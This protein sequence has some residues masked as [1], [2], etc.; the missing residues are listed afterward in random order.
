M[1]LM[2]LHI[3]RLLLMALI[4]LPA[5]TSCYN[6]DEE[7]SVVYG[8][9][10]KYIN[11]TLSVSASNEAVTRA[12]PVG[13]E[14]G[15]G[16][17]KGNNRENLVNTISIFF[18]EDNAG[19]NTSDENTKVAFFAT[20]PVT[21]TDNYYG[22]HN[23]QLGGDSPAGWAGE[24][25]D[26]EVIYSTGDQLLDANA[27]DV[28]KTYHAIVVANAPYTLLSDIIVNETTIAQVREMVVSTVYDG[29]GVNIDAQNFVMSSERDATVTFTNR[30]VDNDRNTITYYFECI[31]IERLAARID[32][33]AKTKDPD[34]TTPTYIEA[35]YDADTYDHAGYVYNVGKKDADEKQDHFV[36]TSI[37]PFNVMNG[38]EYL[39]KRTNNETNPYL[40]K[41]TTTNW[42]LD[43]YSALS[44]GKNGTA[45]PDYLVSKL[46]DVKTNIANDF[47]IVLSTCQTA[48]T[49]TTEGKKFSIAENSVTADNIIIG[50]PKENTLNGG[51]TPLYY[52]AT[53]L[54]FEGYYY[55]KTAT[56]DAS[57]K[58][59]GGTRK[60]FY[61]F[62]RHQGEQD[63]AYSALTDETL[64]TETKCPVSPAMNFGI[65][66]NNIYRVSIES[67]TPDENDIK[68]TLKIKVKKWDKFVHTPI[69][70]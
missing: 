50:Y 58:Y 11:I 70:M 20:Y 51:I 9:A 59:T 66:R 56:K 18:Y 4:V 15:D 47:N 64:N 3:V 37:T 61:H 36:L 27:L 21:K 45:H 33:W 44:G 16:L 8:D 68:V 65:V 29:T 25:N 38:N 55:K 62:L 22:T 32:F 54:A 1:K 39:L 42:V 17:E 31:H 24:N 60:V 5:V 28:T 53:G 69:I 35:G 19:I 30:K 46:T 40:A 13:G 34:Q 12:T 52:Y 63:A 49:G 7:G 48:T 10:T 23:H 57:G 67:I 43:P 2:R 14:T 6:Y 26:N 41:E